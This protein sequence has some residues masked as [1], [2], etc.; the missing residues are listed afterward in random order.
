MKKSAISVK[1]AKYF[2]DLIM[3]SSKIGI[4]KANI[5][6]LNV[7]LGASLSPDNSIIVFAMI[8]SY[9]QQEPNK[10]T[11]IIKSTEYLKIVP[12]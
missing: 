7:F 5:Y 12:I 1:G 6:N 11:Q 4:S 9:T 3:H 8:I 10:S 2:R